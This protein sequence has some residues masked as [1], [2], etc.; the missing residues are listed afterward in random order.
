MKEFRAYHIAEKKMC[1]IKL[2]TDKGAFLIGVKKGK[3]TY[4]DGYKK[5]VIAP[6]DGR[7]CENKEFML[8]RFTGFYDKNGKEIFE[9]D[10]IS[11]FYETDGKNTVVTQQVFWNQPTGSWHLDNTFSQD[12]TESLDLWME[13]NDYEYEV[14]GNIFE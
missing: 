13:L 10:I 8:L 7:F 14:T 9:G 6:D 11:Y 2:L 1:K 4:F 3:N 5:T 12:K